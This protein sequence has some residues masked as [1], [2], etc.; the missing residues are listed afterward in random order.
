MCLNAFQVTPYSGEIVK[1]GIWNMH[2]SLIGAGGECIGGLLPA[3][4]AS[5]WLVLYPSNSF[6]EK[7]T[8]GLSVTNNRKYYYKGR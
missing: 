8:Q 3:E 1:D 6:A 7:H 4:S 5:L 2:R